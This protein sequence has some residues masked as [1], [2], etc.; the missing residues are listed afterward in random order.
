MTDG[1]AKYLETVNWLGKLYNYVNDTIFNG[2]LKRPVITVQTDES[3]K[4]YGWFTLKKVWKEKDAEDGEYEINMCAQFLNRPVNETASTLIHEM[5]HQYALMH[6]I[7]DCSRS[8]TYHNK[9]FKQIAEKHGLKVE[10]IDKY[11]WSRTSLTEETIENLSYFFEKF[12]P[13]LIYHTPV[14][15]GVRLKSSSTRKYI[16]PCCGM[17]VRA[18]R[19]VN[20]MC[21]DCNEFMTVEL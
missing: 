20:I 18:T 13:D 14:Q 7:Q 1:T 3:N 15:K 8:C 2:E 17:S 21:A 16:C 12:P 10:K 5:C 11:G 19:S 9:M 4:A 6:N